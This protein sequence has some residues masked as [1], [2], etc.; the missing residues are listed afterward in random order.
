MLEA[1]TEP[2]D[3]EVLAS[4]LRPR[5]GDERARSFANVEPPK[6]ALSFAAAPRLCGRDLLRLDESERMRLREQGVTWPVDHLTVDELA[7]ILMLVSSAAQL[8]GALAD[9]ALDLY[10]RGEMRER[11]AVLR[12]LPLLP[13]DERLVALGVDACRT[14]VQ[15]VFEAIACEN[16]F[17]ASTFTDPAFAQ[18][19]LKCLFTGA[20]LGRVVG[21]AERT[22]PELA[23]MAK[24][25][26]SERRAA[27][28]SVPE[29]VARIAS[30]E[31]AQT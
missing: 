24:A 25:Y 11:Q 31:G 26:A 22:T 3:P 12:A 29:D 23:R 9:V 30:I 6:L 28:R 17:P 2:V 14:H 7:R 20:S 5:V 8:R 27:G 13:R 18:M 4:I 10:T 15:P 19:V 16:P 21:L 1:R